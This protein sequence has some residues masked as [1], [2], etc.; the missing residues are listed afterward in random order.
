M[1][2]SHKELAA[3]VRGLKDNG[4]DQLTVL[5]SPVCSGQKKSKENGLKDTINKLEAKPT[6]L[7]PTKTKIRPVGGWALSKEKGVKRINQ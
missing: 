7:K 6:K 5:T 3:T 1:T 2:V 4:L